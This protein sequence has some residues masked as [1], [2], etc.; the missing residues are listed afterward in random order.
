MV[1]DNIVGVAEAAARVANE[2]SRAA[3]SGDRRSQDM[4]MVPSL[5]SGAAGGES[6]SSPSRPPVW[7]WGAEAFVP[8]VGP[9]AEPHVEDV[10]NQTTP[11]DVLAD[12]LDVAADFTAVGRVRSSAGKP[13]FAGSSRQ[14]AAAEV[15]F[16]SLR[17]ERPSKLFAPPQENRVLQ[18]P[19]TWHM[20]V[21]VSLCLCPQQAPVEGHQ[22]RGLL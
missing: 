5:A 20:H 21:R 19:E 9:W 12:G 2:A 17:T 16:A 14:R 8:D 4:A 22:R 15:D 7:L 18:E 10:Y 11:N 1:F 13:D 3:A 6:V